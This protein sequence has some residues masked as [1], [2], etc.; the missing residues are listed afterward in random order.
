MPFP[1][2]Q[3]GEQR[4]SPYPYRRKREDVTTECGPGK[5]PDPAVK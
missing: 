5:Q 4:T 1:L 2:N 3:T